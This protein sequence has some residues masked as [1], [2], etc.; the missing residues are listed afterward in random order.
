MTETTMRRAT[1]ALPAIFALGACLLAAC[2]LAP[3]PALAGGNL[4][5]YDIT[6]NTPVVPGF[7]AAKTVPMLWDSRCIPVQVRSN[8]TFDPIPNPLGPPVLTLNQAE[9]GIKRAFDSWND[10]RTSFIKFDLVGRVANPGLPGFDMVNEATFVVPP[11]SGFI[12]LSVPTFF[13][14]DV[15]LAAGDDIDGDGDSDVAAGITTCRDADGDGDIEFPVGFYK[16]G[17]LIDN[18]VLFNSDGFRF[19]VKS[20]D[21]DTNFSSVDLEAVAVHELGHAHGLSHVAGNQ[22][23]ATDGTGATM[24]PF[25]DTGDPAAELGQR[26]LD[27]DDIAFSSFFYPEGSAATGPGAL[28]A[29][30]IPF[31]AVYGIVTGEA[32]DGFTGLP[33]AGGSVSA[34]NILTGRQQATAITGTTQLAFQLSTGNLFFVDPTFDIIDGRYRIPLPL[35]IYNIG[36]EALDGSPVS[37]FQ[38]NTTASIGGFWGQQ[39]FDEELWTVGDNNL[40]SR[41]GLALPVAAVPSVTTPHVDITTNVTHDIES[42]GTLDSIGFTG[43][44]AGTW[45]AVRIPAAQITAANPSTI[46]TGLFDTF[47]GNASVVPVFARAQLATGSVDPGT[48]V[49]TINTVAPLREQA[50]FVG[51]EAD[52]AP[53]YFQNPVAL[54]SQ[55]K[56][57]ITG[58][59]ITDLFLVLQLPTTT[60]FPG[61]SGFPPFIGLDLTPPF[62]TSFFSTNGST[63]SPVNFN[64]MF[65]LGTT[66]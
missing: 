34:T 9:Q 8:S 36:I 30:D 24:Y 6:A 19:T 25:V 20:S 37:P 48:G 66:P 47:V 29:N 40:E 14:A 10:I 32:T 11:G 7:I 13:I 55:I 39:I 3:A 28:Q 2:L 31:N 17:T 35:G 60:P 18:D 38:I 44:P 57:G 65:A 22:I 12:G 54:T 51:Q 62:G 33:L 46:H 26:S 42:F 59:T 15:N 1:P 41:P 27:D 52:F 45:Y 5:A 4:E 23:S 64:F 56:T 16:A 21:V 63:F 43:V 49:A 50:P 58:G 61:V 53:F